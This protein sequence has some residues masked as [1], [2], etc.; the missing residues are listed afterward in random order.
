[1]GKPWGAEAN[2]S[3]GAYGFSSR[4]C[5]GPSRLSSSVPAERRFA[6]AGHAVILCL[7]ET[8]E[9]ILPRGG[10]ALHIEIPDMV[11]VKPLVEA[12]NDILAEL[13]VHTSPRIDD[14]E[15]AH[16]R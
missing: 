15:R 6:V 7:P 11:W 10:K 14:I 9:S 5:Y 3:G 1:M 8:L 13:G 12:V 16:P 4:L 2:Q